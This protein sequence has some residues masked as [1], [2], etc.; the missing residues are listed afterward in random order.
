MPYGNPS[1][2][3]GTASKTLTLDLSV[4]AN[5]SEICNEKKWNLKRCLTVLA[6][7]EVEAIR[8]MKKYKEKQLKEAYKT[9][10]NDI[11]KISQK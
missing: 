2:Q 3:L 7:H 5:L 6:S 11:L 10:P 1:V 9:N 4:W 8:D